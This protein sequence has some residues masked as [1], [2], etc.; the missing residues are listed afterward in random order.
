MLYTANAP[1]ADGAFYY[2]PFLNGGCVTSN[3]LIFSIDCHRCLNHLLFLLNCFLLLRSIDLPCLCTGTR[4]C[5][6]SSICRLLRTFPLMP[7]L[8]LFR[9]KYMYQKLLSFLFPIFRFLLL[10]ILFSL[11]NK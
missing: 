4:L 3:I 2:M 9:S 1:R 8:S 7:F 6:I 11:H 10:V 5:N